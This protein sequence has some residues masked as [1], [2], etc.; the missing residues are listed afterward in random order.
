MTTWIF[1]RH[2]QSTANRARV[3]SGHEDVALTEQGIQQ[4]RDAGE[5]MAEMLRAASDL[6][7][8]SSTLQRAR[9]TTRLVLETAGLSQPFQTRDELR[10]RC[11]GS[12]QG[13]SIDRLKASGERDTLLRWDGRPPNGESLLDLAHRVLPCLNEYDNGGTVFIGCHGGVV[14]T[15]AGLG[16]QM[17]LEELCRWKVP[18]CQPIVRTYPRGVWFEALKNLQPPPAR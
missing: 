10:E 2:G 15:V 14:R 12:W 6:T 17:P 18:N 1:L 4:A 5:A 11:L 8:A 7:I 13:E 3:F 9:E 16:D